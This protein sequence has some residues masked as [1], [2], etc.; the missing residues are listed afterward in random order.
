MYKYITFDTINIYVSLKVIQN[1]KQYYTKNA[2][3]NIQNLHNLFFTTGAKPQIKGNV[4]TQYI[5]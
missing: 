2:N 4:Y 3:C 1:I 5:E